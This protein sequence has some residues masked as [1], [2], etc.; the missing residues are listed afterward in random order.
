MR[1][2]R[3]RP[4]PRR[5]LLAGV[6]AV[7]AA[8]VL[9]GLRPWAGTP[10][11]N[12]PDGVA[13]AS[14]IL[15]SA[16]APLPD[17]PYRGWSS[18]SMQ[19]SKYPGLNPHGYASWLTEANVLAQARAMAREL[20]PYGYTYIS[21]DAGWGSN[22]KWSPHYDRNGLQYANEV[23]F[24]HGMKW[25]ADQIHAL[26]LKAGIYLTVGLNKAN[27]RGGDFP[28]KGTKI[29]GC[30]THDIV[31]ADLRTTNGWDSA[32]KIDFDKPCAQDFIDS[33]A[34]KFADWGYDLV[35]IDGVGPGSYKTDADHDNRRDIEAWHKAIEKTGR[36]I[37]LKLSWALDPS[38]IKTWQDNADSW[39]IENDVECYCDTLTTWAKSVDDR[40]EDAPKWVQ[41]AGPKGWNNLDSIDLAVGAMDGLTDDERRSMM[42]LWTISAAPLFAGDDL[43]KMDDLGRELMT[44]RDVLAIQA[45]GRPASP[46]TPDAEKQVWRVDNGDGTWTVALFNLGDRPA[47]VRARWSDLGFAGP[48]LVH[49]V[50]AGTDLEPAETDWSARIPAHGTRLL[51]VTP[52]R[53]AAGYEAEAAANRGVDAS[54]ASCTGCAG[55]LKVGELRGS[56]TFRGIGVRQTGDYDVTV[57]YV[58]GSAGR[59]LTIAANNETGKQIVLGGAKDGRWDRPRSTTLRV[60]FH[61]GRDNTLTLAATD[62]TPGPDIDRIVVQAAS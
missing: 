21:L 49:D 62:G 42:T 28:V 8:L 48:A 16:A 33:Q 46:V 45:R 37:H 18:W 32:Y 61:E 17:P 52:I 43:T 20:K 39:R 7:V 58:D 54:V 50:W 25:M 36:A 24:P 10:T 57:S 2:T 31:Y 30:S 12:A 53:T 55:G 56:L 27:Y 44:N 11:P 41:Y 47:V 14:V 5:L 19:S 34:Q 51:R 23:R 35:K 40:F 6:V 1:A 4:W 13:G 60:R 29:A 22:W 9:V 15:P 26:G 3:S 38:A 59:P